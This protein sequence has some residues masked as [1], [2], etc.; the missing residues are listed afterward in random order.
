M[1]KSQFDVVPITTKWLHLNSPEC[2]SGMVV[3]IY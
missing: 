1:E 2:N 3:D